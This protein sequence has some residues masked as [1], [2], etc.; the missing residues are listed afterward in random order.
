[1]QDWDRGVIIGR[2]S[3]GKGL[4][5]KPFQLPDGSMIRLTVAHYYTPS[6]RCIQK[7]Y[8]LGDE[9]DYDLDVSNRLKHGEL[10][11][12]DSIQF[13]DTTKYYTNNKRLVH[14]GG[15]I[16]PDI[17]VPLDTTQF[18]TFFQDLQRKNTFYDFILTHVD[19]NRAQFKK[20]YPDLESF[21][22]NYSV[23]DK[24]YEEFIANAEKLGVKRDTAGMAISDKLI[25]LNI[26]ALIARELY[27]A[28]GLFEVLNELNVP[29]QKAMEAIQTNTFEKMKIAAK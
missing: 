15:G 25:R 1:M 2:R 10:T 26:K 13:K 29:L 8:T 5:Q 9:E 7:P 28:E 3:F 14:G 20:E 16:M 27:N 18:S 22:K 24:F 23:S 12:P 19:N 21:K 11:N 4:V 17:F 6:G